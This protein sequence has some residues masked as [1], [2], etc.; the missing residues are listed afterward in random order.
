MSLCRDVLVIVL[1]LF[2]MYVFNAHE[3]NCLLVEYGGNKFGTF[4]VFDTL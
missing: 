3:Q 2:Y 1:F 4:D